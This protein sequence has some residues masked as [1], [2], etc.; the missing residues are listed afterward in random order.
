MSGGSP[1]A[2][3]HHCGMVHPAGPHD[4]PGSLCSVT[5]LLEDVDFSRVDQGS[6][7]Q[8]GVNGGN[9][10]APA[11]LAEDSS[12]GGFTSIVSPHLDGFGW[13]AAPHTPQAGAGVLGPTPGVG[14]RVGMPGGAG[15]EAHRVGAGPGQPA[16]GGA[17]LHGGAGLQV[18]W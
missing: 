10:L 11:Y 7:V 6:L 13:V 18:G 4:V 14:G 16:A 9:P 17:G 2:A 1:L 5:I 3:P 15:A 8:F 12:L